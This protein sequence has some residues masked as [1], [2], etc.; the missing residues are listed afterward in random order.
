MIH[1]LGRVI[2][3]I[4]KYLEMAKMVH[5]HYSLYARRGDLKGDANP[6]KNK[7]K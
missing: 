2:F 1:H 3:P 4:R 5:Q 6:G 7:Q